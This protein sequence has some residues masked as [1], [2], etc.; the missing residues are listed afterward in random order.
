M[1]TREGNKEQD[2]LD[3]ATSVFA[4]Y[5]YHGAKMAKIAEAAGVGAGSLYL[6]FKD[7]A[8]ILSG[9]FERLLKALAFEMDRVTARKDLTGIE[10][11]DG[12]IDLVFDMFINNA[13]LAL[14]FV[15]EH[16]NLIMDDDQIASDPYEQFLERAEKVFIQGYNE[17]LFN[18][19][20]DYRVYRHFLFGGLRRL[21]HEWAR[22]PDDF[23][24]NG[25]RRDV[26]HF[27][28]R[29]IMAPS[30]SQGDNFHELQMVKG[31]DPALSPVRDTPA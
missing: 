31:I 5:G 18:P 14:V 13:P 3:A 29:G 8:G 26:K 17:G 1:R 23:P 12:I 24:I 10:K 9:I 6:Y 2:I 27:I 20:L 7:K 4:R 28:K 11:L 15:N 21:I 22:H 25:I 16:N 30:K 19:D